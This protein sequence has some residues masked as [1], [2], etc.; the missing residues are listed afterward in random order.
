MRPNCLSLDTIRTGKQIEKI[1][2][3]NGYT[4]KSLQ[5]ALNLGCPQPIYRWINGQIM[6]S[7]D[8]LYHM[9]KLFNMHMEDF[10]VSYE[11]ASDLPEEE[12][13]Y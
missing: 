3:Q 2:R 1:L 11:D 5:I 7:I 10:V 9:H 8:H 6:P 13:T 4:V 12:N